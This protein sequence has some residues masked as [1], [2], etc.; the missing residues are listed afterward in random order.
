[1]IIAVDF[2]GTL[3]EFKYPEIGAPNKKLIEEIKSRT[4]DTFILWT[5]RCGK[6]L[7][8]AVEWCKKQGLNFQ[9]INENAK[10]R[11]EKYGNDTRKI[12]ADEYWDDKGKTVCFIKDT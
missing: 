4:S 11:L 10:E 5:C 12:S 3:C 2:D 1:M 6:R 7:E 8:E 9:Y